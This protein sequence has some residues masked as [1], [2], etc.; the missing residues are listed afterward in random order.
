MT[1]SVFFMSMPYFR[2]RNNRWEE[3]QLNGKSTYFILF[4]RTI[5][6][7][8]AVCFQSAI[9]AKRK[10]FSASKLQTIL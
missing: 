4:L 2:C 8:R 3:L 5:A 1:K 10:R 6:I 7:D 9:T